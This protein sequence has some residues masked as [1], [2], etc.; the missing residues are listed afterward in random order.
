[1]AEAMPLH[2]TPPRTEVSKLIPPTTPILTVYDVGAGLVSK[3]PVAGNRIDAGLRRTGVGVLYDHRGGIDLHRSATLE[4]S[5]DTVGPGHNLVAGLQA[6]SYLDV[7]LAGD[8]GGHGDE[9][10]LLGLGRYHGPAAGRD[11]GDMTFRVDGRRSIQ[12]ERLNR[13]RKDIRLTRGGD[14]S[15][16][17]EAGPEFIGGLI[18]GDDD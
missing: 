9:D 7:G 4:I 5:K 13:D 18:D 6:V 14:F 16:C 12:G 8:A 3:S 11:G 15:G 1:M 10:A 2:K 17:G